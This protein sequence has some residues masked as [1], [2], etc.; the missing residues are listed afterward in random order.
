MRGWLLGLSVVLGACANSPRRELPRAVEQAAIGQTA[1]PVYTWTQRFRWPVKYT[2]EM[3]YDAARERTFL[4][5]FH[6]DP[7][8]S[9]M[10]GDTWEW[11]GELANWSLLGAGAEMLRNADNYFSAGGARAYD[12]QRK[13]TVFYDVLNG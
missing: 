2:N 3:V 1:Q 5:C 10:L 4:L 11:N 9:R 6:P 7:L 8:S 12:S 13:V